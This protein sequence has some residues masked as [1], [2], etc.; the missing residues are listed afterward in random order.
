M[1][2]LIQVSDNCYYIQSP[3]KIGIVKIS[4]DE[5]VLID[6]GNDKDAGKKVKRIM[7]S[8]GWS[9]KAIYNTHSHADHIGG[10]QYLQKQTGCNVYAPGIERDFTE[11]P[12]LEPAFLYGA[13]PPKSLKH[14]FLMAQESVVQPLTE[15]CLPEGMELIQLPGHWWS[16]VGFRTSDNIVYLADC[17]SSKETLEKYQISVLVDVQAYLETLKKIQ[18][19]KAS[20]LIPSHAEP[21]EDITDL[22]EYNIRKVHEIGDTIVRI[23]SEPA[24]FDYVLQKIFEQYQLTMTFEQHALVGSTVRSY[25][26]WLQEQGRIRADIVDNKLIWQATTESNIENRQEKDQ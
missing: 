13:N 15:Q 18:S 24:N 17:L 4:K 26:T 22:A 7:D 9:L 2:E 14:K 5:V 6:S 19:L 16:M 8:N 11:H 20:L 23:C 12:I 10:N 25:L 21:A 1:Y 3:A